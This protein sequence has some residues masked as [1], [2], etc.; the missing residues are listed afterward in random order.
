[1]SCGFKRDL[2]HVSL[3][4]WYKFDN[5]LHIVHDGATKGH[6]THRRARFQ[7]ALARP[8]PPKKPINPPPGKRITSYYVIECDT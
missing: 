1:M 5:Y 2:F 6:K 3:F 7:F 4:M 8:V